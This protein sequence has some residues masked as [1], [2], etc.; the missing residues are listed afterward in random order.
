M[1]KEI[2]QRL[3]AFG[4]L[5]VDIELTYENFVYNGGQLGR[6]DFENLIKWTASEPVKPKKSNKK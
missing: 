1:D 4:M 3:M 2:K 5:D 6:A